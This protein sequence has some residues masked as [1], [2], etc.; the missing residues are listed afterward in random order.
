MKTSGCVFLFLLIAPFLVIAGE[1][2]KA[3][4]VTGTD[5]AAQCISS[6][7]VTNI[8]GREVMVP[9]LGF[10]LDPGKHSIKGRALVNTSFCKALGQGSQRYQIEPLEENFEAGKTYYLGYDHSSAN[11]NDWQL[12]IWKVETADS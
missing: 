12:V 1:D 9:E 11:R 6:I 10:D 8:D 5:R 2:G 7:H 4:I 3:R